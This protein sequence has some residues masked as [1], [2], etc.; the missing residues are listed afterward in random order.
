MTSYTSLGG[1]GSSPGSS[2]PSTPSHAQWLRRQFSGGGPSSCA[3]LYYP[4]LGLV[5]TLVTQVGREWPGGTASPWRLPGQTCW[6]TGGPCRRGGRA[7]RAGQCLRNICICKYLYL[8]LQIFIFVFANIYICIFR[9]PG[10]LERSNLVAILQLVVKSVVDAS[11]R[12]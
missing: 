5:A 7:G 3:S 9:D 10:A 6:W 1:E 4:G 8:Y 2:T 12:L 11:L